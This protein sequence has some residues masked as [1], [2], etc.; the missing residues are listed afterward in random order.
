VTIAKK[1]TFRLI[2]VGF[3]V[4]SIVWIA[5]RIVIHVTNIRAINVSIIVKYVIPQWRTVQIVGIPAAK[6]AESSCVKIASEVAPNVKKNIVENVSKN[7]SV[8]NISF[9][10]FFFNPF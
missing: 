1:N 9:V 3:V 10:S 7:T 8:T 4:L 5:I 2:D 6:R